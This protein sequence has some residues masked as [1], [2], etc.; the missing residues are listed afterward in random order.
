MPD[1]F[2]ICPMIRSKGANEIFGFI[3]VSFNEGCAKFSSAG[4]ICM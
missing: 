2:E 1:C 3:S 4:H